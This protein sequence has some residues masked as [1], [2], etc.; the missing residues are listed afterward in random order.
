MKKIVVSALTALTLS[1]GAVLAADMPVKAVRAPAAPPAWDLAFGAALMNDYIF[2]GV[3]QSNRKA[4]VAAYFEPRYN[5]NPNLQLYLGVAGESISFPNR[6]AS[7]IDIYGGV[8]STLGKLVLD[9]GAWYYWYPGGQ[10][11]SATCPN[12]TLPIN[13]NVVKADMSFWELYF[14]PTWNVTD[15]FAI[16]GSL[17]YSPSVMNSG[18]RGFYYSGNAKYAFPALANGVQVYT[19]GELGYWNLGTSD[20]FY[21]SIP[22]KSYT[23]WNLGVGWTYKVFTVDLRYTDTNLSK[24]DCNAFT[25]DHTAYATGYITPINAAPGYGSNWCG[26][27]FT[28]KLSADLTVNSNLK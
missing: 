18:A 9:F 13:G 21:G 14:K 16:G 5:L 24:G 23:T 1:T 25:S 8:R 11:Y 4:S 12:G 2:R 26:A 19:S 10:C 20:A 17:F 27:A 7:E 22:F 15:A 6:A 3:T 28:A